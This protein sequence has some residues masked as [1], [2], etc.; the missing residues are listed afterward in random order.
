MYCAL[1]ASQCK[2]RA[3]VYTTAG[4]QIWSLIFQNIMSHEPQKIFL[5]S[6]HHLKDLELCHISFRH[7]LN[8]TS[9]SSRKRKF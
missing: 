8:Q 2:T 4:A 6:L 1:N 7:N 5:Q 3:H 9:P